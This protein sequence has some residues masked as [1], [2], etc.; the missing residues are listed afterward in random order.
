MRRGTIGLSLIVAF[1][2]CQATERTIKVGILLPNSAT[3]EVATYAKYTLDGINLAAKKKTFR[4]NGKR[5]ELV[6][7]EKYAGDPQTTADA[8]RELKEKGAKIVIG[9]LTSAEAQAILPVMSEVKV[10]VILPAATLNSLS[11]NDWI[12]R[13]CI[14]NKQM[15]VAIA[16]AAKDILKVK[17]AAV[18]SFTNNPY[19]QELA[20]SFRN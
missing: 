4:V 2:G 15:A 1:T 16:Y 10:P 6:Y 5:I 17:E 3:G 8:L 14:S 7:P 20:E 11:E 9:P 18:I 12:W 19:S 13:V